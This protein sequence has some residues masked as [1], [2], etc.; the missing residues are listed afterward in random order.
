MRRLLAVVVFALPCMPADGSAQRI[1]TF[2]PATP[3]PARVDS[4]RL[5][6]NESSVAE[7]VAW[8]ALI[9]VGVALTDHAHAGQPDPVDPL[10]TH[11]AAAHDASVFEVLDFSPVGVASAAV[12]AAAV[13]WTRDRLGNRR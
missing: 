7:Q 4:A 5:D 6:E 10:G 12:A 11:G 8:G 13:E 3:L 9:A 1:S 2:E